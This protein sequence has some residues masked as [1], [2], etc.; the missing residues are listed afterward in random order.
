MKVLIFIMSLTMVTPVMAQQKLDKDG[1]EITSI[2]VV[3]PV[4]RILLIGKYDFVGAV[5]FLHNEEKPDGTYSMYEFFEHEK[6]EFR[7]MGEGSVL[8][9]KL[10][11]GKGI[12]FH[13]SPSKLAGP[14][15]K[16]KNF[17]LF[18]HAGGLNHSTVYFWSKPNKVD[19]KVR[20]APTPWK[21]IREVNLTDPRIKWF[22]YT[23]KESSK[24]IL[25]DKLWD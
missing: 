3:M 9:K 8:L 25:I 11:G 10:P 1:V 7:K 23:D 12:F 24:V 14:P 21:E 13:E 2:C 6:G 22:T 20:M 5:K 19:H 16:L 18:A 15:L 4:G 17:S